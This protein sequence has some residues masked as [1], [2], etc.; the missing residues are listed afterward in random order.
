M[1][2]FTA[3]SNVKLDSR[4][5]LSAYLRALSN[6]K[7]VITSSNDI[8]DDYLTVVKDLNL[9]HNEEKIT[10]LSELSLMVLDTRIPLLHSAK[11]LH[12]LLEFH[13]QDLIENSPISV[14]KPN[15]FYQKILML[16]RRIQRKYPQLHIDSPT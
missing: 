8:V 3:I 6:G 5:S 11:W 9:A 1:K 16:N 12:D 14:L 15:S 10:F 7:N 13:Q 4:K 2:A